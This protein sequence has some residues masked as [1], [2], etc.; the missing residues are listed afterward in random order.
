LASAID[1]ACRSPER[2]R[3]MGESARQLIGSWNYDAT[4]RGYYSALESCLGV[5]GHR[6]PAA[7]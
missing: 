1:R 5:A 2:L 7:S 6:L 4:L 3:A